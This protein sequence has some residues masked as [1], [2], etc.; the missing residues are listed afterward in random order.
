MLDLTEDKEQE[1]TTEPTEEEVK[2]LA[3]EQKAKDFSDNPDDFVNIHECLVVIDARRDEQ[4]RVTH[5][6]QKSNIRTEDEA[7]I[8]TG[9]AKMIID[10]TLIHAM[11]MKAQSSIIK[12]G[13]PMP[14]AKGAFGGIF[15]GR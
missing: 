2:Q 7:H 9:R 15:K 6:R 5:Y 1:P 14:K 4:G 11:R 13:T 10:T 3:A 8:A 12:P